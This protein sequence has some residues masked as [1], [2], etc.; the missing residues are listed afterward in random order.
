MAMTF[1]LQRLL[2]DIRY[3][4]ERYRQF[5][6]V[7]FV[8]LVS[9]TG[10]PTQILFVVGG[11]LVFLG[12]AMRLWA[13]GH[14]KKNKALATDG[15]Y[16]YVRHPQYVGNVTLG[17]GFAL[18]SALWWSVPVMIF[19]LLAFYPH[20]IHHEDENLHRIFKE[21]WEE[22]RKKTRALIPRLSPF[23]PTQRGSWSFIQSLRQNGEPIIDLFLL[24]WLYFLSM[25]LH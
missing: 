16:A 14:V 11:A 13:S 20:A 24:F 6:G 25:R 3:H 9:A 8:I 15:P 4:R 2:H 10:E 1:G 18:A 19:I 22:W 21:E 5:V 12:I 17:F 23:R 7:C